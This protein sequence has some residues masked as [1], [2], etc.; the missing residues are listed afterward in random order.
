[1]RCTIIPIGKNK[2]SNLTDTYNCRAIALSN[3]V[4]KI[5]ECVSRDKLVIERPVDAHQ[6]EL[7]AR[8]SIYY[9]VLKSA[10]KYYYDEGSDNFA[11][12]VDF[13]KAFDE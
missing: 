5:F 13:S 11:C 2:A 4:I 3:S 9:D 12:C 1:M 7:S 10:I 6:F 8:L